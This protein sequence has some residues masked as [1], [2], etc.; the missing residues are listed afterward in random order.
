[1]RHLSP[2]GVS[3]NI[4]YIPSAITG[5]QSVTLQLGRVVMEQLALLHPT[6]DV[7]VRDVVAQPL[8]HFVLK[9]SE[10]DAAVF[11]EVLR[12]YLAADIV[13]IGA[14]M[15]N[16][17]IPSQLKAW[18]DAIAV[19]GTTFRYT[20]NG[21]EGLFPDKQI[22]IVGSQGGVH[23]A[24]TDFQERYLRQIFAFLGVNNVEVIG[25]RGVGLGPEHKDKEIASIVERLQN[26]QCPAL[27]A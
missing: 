2:L 21:P 10:Q 8:P 17:S 9:R 3:M 18:I 6:A 25:A 7:V 1:M 13:V 20:A 16:F 5:E 24:T 22:I 12:E 4:L 23:D 15:Y 19:A 27:A 11:A 26:R 14:P